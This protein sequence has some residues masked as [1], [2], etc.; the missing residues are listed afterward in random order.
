MITNA[1]G[2]V[3]PEQSDPT[4]FHHVLD[5]GCGPGGWAIEVAKSFPETR[6]VGIDI[7][8]EMVQ[9]A[10]TQAQKQHVNQQVEFRVM[11]ALGPLAFPDTCFDLV[12]LRYGF[13][14]IR[15]WDWANVLSELLRVTSLGGIIRLI[16][17]EFLQESNCPTWRHLNEILLSALFRAGHLSTETSTGTTAHLAP[18]LQ[19]YGCLHVQTKLYALEYRGKTEAGEAYYQ[20]LFHML[21]I[22]PP[23]L[24]KW[25]CL[26]EDYDALCL[27][28]LKEVHHRDFHATLCFQCAWGTKPPP[29][30]HG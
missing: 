19:R 10:C 13:S 18:L 15:V 12:N 7:S 16:E 23:F 26:P 6:I 22:I 27:R 24:K 21:Q 2:G 29:S 1:M 20:D 17:P 25:G 3:F 28:A 5:V 14:F 30:T 4:R 9:H 11:D 8:D